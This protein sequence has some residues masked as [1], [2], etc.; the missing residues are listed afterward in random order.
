L[1]AIVGEL[2]GSI[3]VERE[4]KTLDALLASGL[5][6]AEIVLGALA[7]GLLRSGAWVFAGIPA[8]LLMVPLLGIDPRLILLAYAG[9]GA[10]GFA[11]S[12]IAVLVSTGARSVRAAASGTQ[13]LGWSWMSLPF[14]VI[15][16]MPLIW[17][18]GSRWLAPLFLGLLDS[19]PLGVFATVSGMVGRG[20]LFVAL[21]RMIAY[22]IAGGAVLVLWAIARLRP[23]SRAL[24]DA[25]TRSLL[26]RRLRR[27]RRRPACG[28]DPMLWKELHATPGMRFIDKINMWFLL[29]FLGL[30][31][32]YFARLA[33]VELLERG[34][35]ASAGGGSPPIGGAD[36]TVVLGRG[37]APTPGMARALFNVVLREVTTVITLTYL[38]VLGEAAAKG[39]AGEREQDTWPGLLATPLTGREI[40]RAKRAGAV[41]RVRLL[42]ATLVGF[43]A[44]GLA[45]GSV[46]P[47]GFLA[48]LTAL[49]VSSWF[50][51]ALGTALALWSRTTGQSTERTLVPVVLLTFS[52]LIPRLLPPSF[53]SIIMG[54]GSLPLVSWLALLSYDDLAAALRTGAFPQLDVLGIDT[55]EGFAR[56]LATYLV[57]IVGQSIAAI[58]LTRAAV[59]SFDAAVG[60]TWEF[61]TKTQRGT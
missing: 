3:A 20:S 59:R 21:P 38:M 51:A 40:L 16:C 23:A 42:P 44:I 58:L 5:S 47:L 52:G 9:V 11:L 60:R 26:L 27:P 29:G 53:A 57:N 39:V 28:D 2:P 7:S 17:P 50:V 34:Y 18:A 14:L 4:R 49:A 22:E 36:W 61:T 32:S 24:A 48:A 8:V 31:I 55:G 54:A 13:A 56:V 37:I 1:T 43:W 10:T 25:E 15:V 12:A 33:F 30:G 46:H 6:G 41:W 19:S 45:A 35:G